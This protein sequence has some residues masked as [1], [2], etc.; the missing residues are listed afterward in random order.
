MRETE[1]VT[2][3]PC[4]YQEAIPGIYKKHVVNIKLSPI[5]G[6]SKSGSSRWY[7]KQPHTLII[8]TCYQSNITIPRISSHE[9]WLWFIS[10][11]GFKYITI[12]LRICISQRYPIFESIGQFVIDIHIVTAVKWSPIVIIVYSV[13]IEFS[14]FLYMHAHL[15]LIVSKMKS[16]ASLKHDRSTTPSS[17]QMLTESSQ[18]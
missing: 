4:S 15:F 8:Y 7:I 13:Q 1:A 17:G 2:R 18:E 6:W 5:Y 14:V 11:S 3:D 9:Y 12:P 16:W 10:V